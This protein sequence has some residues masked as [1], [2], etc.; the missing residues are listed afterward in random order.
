M[1]RAS[2]LSTWL[3]FSGHQN[4]HIQRFGNVCYLGKVTYLGFLISA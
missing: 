1:N 3:A 4:A 2:P